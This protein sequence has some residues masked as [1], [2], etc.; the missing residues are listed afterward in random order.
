VCTDTAVLFVLVLDKQ[1]GHALL[2]N[3]ELCITSDEFVT[4]SQQSTIVSFCKPASVVRKCF[5][6]RKHDIDY[7]TPIP[8]RH[9][10]D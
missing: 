2:R 10:L 7:E 5:R 4:V 3:R 9:E 6:W 1:P 8:A